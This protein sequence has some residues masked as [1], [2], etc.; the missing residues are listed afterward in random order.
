V[1][2]HILA[3]FCVVPL[4]SGR[5]PAAPRP[6][7]CSGLLPTLAYAIAPKITV[8]KQ[9]GENPAGSA[10]RM[11][12]SEHPLFLGGINGLGCL[13][14]LKLRSGSHPQSGLRFDRGERY[15]KYTAAAR[16]ALKGG[17]RPDLPSGVLRGHWFPSTSSGIPCHWRCILQS[18]WMRRGSTT[19]PI[20]PARRAGECCALEDRCDR[21]LQALLKI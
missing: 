16:Q 2:K 19:V 21:L 7:G 11:G 17:I 1:R 15:E 10:S 3:D 6:G 18:G 4:H 13:H 20:A 14:L 9:G 5:C 12:I 8:K